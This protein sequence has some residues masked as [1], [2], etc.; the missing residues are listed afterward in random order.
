MKEGEGGEY[1]NRKSVERGRE[2]KISMTIIARHGNETR[3][4]RER[5]ERDKRENRE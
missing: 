4:T 2:G 3:E 1:M 5:I